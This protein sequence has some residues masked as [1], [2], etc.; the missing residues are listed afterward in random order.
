MWL[1]RELGG[2]IERWV[3]L[4]RD[5]CLYRE[6]GFYRVMG[7]FTERGSFAERWVVIYRDGWLHREMGGFIER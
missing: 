7:A 2:F 6:M 4:Q 3:A 5:G 1:Y